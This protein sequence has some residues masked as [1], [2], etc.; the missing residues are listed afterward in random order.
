MI[1]MA[2]SAD[3]GEGCLLAG[4]HGLISRP[5]R[6]QE[7]FG[8]IERALLAPVFD[9]RV[10]LENV[11]DDMELLLE[12][13]GVAQREFPEL[14]TRIRMAISLGDALQL[15][16]SAHTIKGWLGTYTRSGHETFEAARSLE[17]MG[18]EGNLAGAEQAFTALERGVGS[19]LTYLAA[20]T[21][22][23]V[24]IGTSQQ[25]WQTIENLAG[26]WRAALASSAVRPTEMV[27]DEEGAVAHAGGDGEVLR[28]LSDIFLANRK[29]F[30]FAIR[31]AV[32]KGSGDELARWAFTLKNLAGM[33][34]GWRVW[35]AASTLEKIG[36]EGCPT[37][38]AYNLLEAAVG[39][40][41]RCLQEFLQRISASEEASTT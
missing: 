38:E 22:S 10:G 5:I 25:V 15:K 26:A 24:P 14:M 30:M 18:T 27:F 8:A 11:A 33:L 28:H 23:D 37:L 21:S 2:S 35:E 40:F 31:Q 6:P 4:L 9:P 41:E 12:L 16:R 34:C 1:G 13:A 20:F 32:E 17:R 39:D 3:C 19:F 36:Q 29:G 7:L